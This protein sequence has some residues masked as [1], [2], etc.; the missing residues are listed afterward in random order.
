MAED[1]ELKTWVSDKL[2]SLLGYSQPTLVQFVIRLEKLVESGLPSSTETRSFAKE[3]FTRVPRK[4]ADLSSYQREEREAAMLVKKQRTYQMLEASDDEEEVS[5]HVEKERRVRRRVTEDEDDIESEERLRD[6]EE[7]EQLERNLREKDAAATRKLTEPKLS[8]KEQEEAI[9]R[10]NAVDQNDRQTLRKVSRQEYLKKREVK[11]LEE[12][13]DD[14]EDEQYLF[15]GVKLTEAEYREL[16]YKREIYDL[17]K[18]RSEDVDDINEY[19]MPEAYDQDGVVNQEKRFAAAMQRYRDPN[20]GEKMNPFAEQEAWE[21]HQ[22]GKATLKY[23]SKNKKQTTDDYQ[24]VFEDQIE[25]ITASVMDGDKREELTNAPPVNNSGDK[26]A[27]QKLQDDRK[28]LPIYPYRE[29]LLQAIHEHQV[30]VIIGETGSGKTT[31][32]PQYLHEAGYTKRGMIGCTQPRRV[33]AMSVSARVSQE[34]G[35]KLG[36]EVGYSIRF[37]DCTSEKTVL[38]YMT[39]G[40][41][42][43][44]FLGEPDLASYSVVMVDEAHERTLSTDILFG[45]VKDVARFRPDLKLLI[46]SATLDAEKFSDYF[47]SAPIFKIPGRRFPVE[48]HYTKAPEADYLDAAIVTVLQIHVTQ[49]PGDILVFFTGQEEIETAEEVLRHRTRGLGTKIAE[50][51]ICPIYANLPTELQA[52][53]FEPTP[54][55]ARKVV[56]ATNIAETSLTIDGISYVVDPGFCKMKSYNPRTGMESLLVNPVSK[57][58]ADQRAGRSG[59]T[60]PGKCFRLFTAYNFQNDLDA[61]TVPEIQRTNLANVVLTLKSLGIH[62]LL[63]FDFMDPPPAE[64]LLKALELLF[65]LNALNKVG[66]LTKMGR[67]MAEFPLDPMLSKMI[68][69]SEKYKCS[70]EIISIAAMLSVGNSIFYRPKDKQ[71]HADNARMNFHTGNVGDHIAL[72]KV[73]DSWKETNFNTQWCYENYIQVRSMKRARDIRD[74]LEGL[75][76]RVEIEASSNPNELDAI[77]KAITSGF[78]H[79]SARLQKSGAYKTVKNPQTVHMHPTSGLAQVLPRWVVYHELVL[80]TKE[81][82]RQVDNRI[83]ARV[84]GGDRTSLLPAKGRGRWKEEQSDKVHHCSVAGEDELILL[85]GDSATE[86]IKC[87]IGVVTEY[88]LLFSA[89]DLSNIG[90]FSWLQS[91]PSIPVPKGLDVDLSFLPICPDVVLLSKQVGQRNAILLYLDTDAL[92][93]VVVVVPT[94]VED[95]LLFSGWFGAFSGIPRSPLNVLVLIKSRCNQQDNSPDDLEDVLGDDADADAHV[96]LPVGSPDYLE[97]SPAGSHDYLEDILGDDADA[98]AYVQFLAGSPDYLEDVLGDDVDADAHVQLPTSIPDYLEDVLGDDADAD[99]HAQLLLGSDIVLC[100]KP[101][102]SI[103]FRKRF[104]FNLLSLNLVKDN[105]MRKEEDEIE[106]EEEKS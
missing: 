70:E 47:D 84:A 36:H 38:K 92:S 88:I 50:L 14:I 19:R 46:S 60:G 26:S 101:D 69:A 81:Y 34:M 25:F 76:E 53:I 99:A 54:E 87:F 48:I 20:S 104:F 68:V 6:Q 33:A 103:L 13:R 95:L 66:E 97:E 21:E 96:Q 62:D 102:N 42:L 32:I 7:R 86:A 74:Q 71:V 94:P 91:H 27:E 22:I 10:S 8:K 72:L 55:G 11:K 56:L 49:P 59:R 31:Q 51:I 83:E 98:Y 45:L 93:G 106:D 23:G 73:Y 57:A 29:E 17:A 39:D 15:D 16:R 3:V 28:T 35:V 2:M 80:T 89:N 64:A 41:L 18:K 67:R 4:S 30:I 61:N 52:K 100:F 77:K 40:M 44:E 85:V 90:D 75:L 63:S 79:H 82:M 9:R 105:R 43:R 5:V 1:R 78:F 24:Y 12:I 37:E 65:A 58:S